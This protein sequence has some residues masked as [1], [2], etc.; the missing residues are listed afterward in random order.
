MILFICAKC[1][2][3]FKTIGELLEHVVIE[4]EHREEA[5]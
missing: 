4:H 3:T 1:R 2:I 5:E